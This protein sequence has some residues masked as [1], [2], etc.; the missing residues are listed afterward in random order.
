MTV[1]DELE[2][3]EIEKREIGRYT[4]DRI[5]EIP[6]DYLDIVEDY[7][8][9]SEDSE[10]PNRYL[11]FEKTRRQ[12]KDLRLDEVPTA[13]DLFKIKK[14]LNE[15]DLYEKKARR[16]MTEDEEGKHPSPLETDEAKLHKPVSYEIEIRRYHELMEYLDTECSDERLLRSFIAPAQEK[17]EDGVGLYLGIGTSEVSGI[18]YR[19][20]GM[21]NP[22]AVPALAGLAREAAEI[23]QE[24]DRVGGIG[25]STLFNV[26]RQYGHLLDAL[27]EDFDESE[28]MG[29]GI[30]DH[31]EWMNHLIGK[32]REAWKTLEDIGVTR[33]EIEGFNT[34]EVAS[35]VD[36]LKVR[37][38]FEVETVPTYTDTDMNSE[39][40][41]KF[42]QKRIEQDTDKNNALRLLLDDEGN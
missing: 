3:S 26:T 21:M 16:R 1:G 32:S 42:H 24:S 29:D 28:L 12:A 37:D 25:Q 14:Y 7:M 15:T 18:K 6:T 11:E 8:S 9:D 40:W 5:P 2:R 4:D 33:F 39:E 22:E 35:L 17:V 23:E 20:D 30:E 10:L 38:K 31:D 34:K 41:R 36:H 19:T 13:E 27:G